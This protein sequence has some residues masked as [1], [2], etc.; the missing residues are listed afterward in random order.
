MAMYKRTLILFVVI[1]LTLSLGASGGVGAQTSNWT[2]DKSSETVTFGPGEDAITDTVT[3][4]NDDRNNS[5]SLSASIDG[6]HTVTGQPGT[7]GPGE[8]TDIQVELRSSGS[9]SATLTV[10]GGGKTERV[11]YT[12]ETP[13]YVEIS[14]IPDWLDDEGVLR[15]DSRTA[16]ITVEETGGHQGFNGIDI[17][18]DDDGIS[19]LENARVSAGGST[20]VTVTFTADN[21]ADQY[22]DIGG[23]LE[24]DPNELGTDYD[25]ESDV[26]LE[27][28]VAFPAQFGDV[29]LDLEEFE[30]DEPQS[31]GSITRQTT[32]EVENSGD[33]E[34]NF[35][36]V[37]IG[38]T[39]FSD[40]EVLSEPNSIGPGET[41]SVDL[42]IT[43][44]TSLDEGAYDFDATLYANNVD[45]S[46]LTDTVDIEH[47]VEMSVSTLE[48]RS[49]DVPIGNTDS[50]SITV[51]EELGY[52]DIENV[53][54]TLSEGP[55][56]WI[57]VTNDID[58]S[59]DTN[60]SSDV[61][62]EIQFGPNADIGSTYSWTFVISGDEVANREVTVSATP[63][64]L[65]LEPLKESLEEAPGESQ[66]LEQTSTETLE[67]VNQMDNQIRE[68]EIPREDVTT[69]LT[70]GDGVIRYLEAI[71]TVDNSVADGNH[72]AAQEELIRAAVA[73]D[74]MSVYGNA[75]QDDDLRS[76]ASS[77]RETAGTELSSRI[78]TQE[79]HYEEQLES[80]DTTPVEEA[81]IKTELARIASLQGDSERAESLEAEADSAFETYSTL[82]GEGETKRQEAIDDWEEMESDIF[83]TVVGQ[84]LILNPVH[85]DKFEDRSDTLLSAYDD[86][87][88]AF[89]EAGETTRAEAVTEERA[90]RANALT[91]ARWSLFVSMTIGAV[92]IISIITHT[93]RGMY[94]YIEDSKESISG[95][96]LM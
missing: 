86:A 14:G 75:I 95:D 2:L 31:V 12:V 87:E 39:P 30:F 7:L 59:I 19:G 68:G 37:A 10:N 90:Q 35:N 71:D 41:E 28:F 96:F 34:L 44:E 3:V 8:S 58:S 54:M 5:V 50:A 52:K 4:R 82:V 76:R 46:D 42:E 78:E 84:Q 93:A 11:D 65:N 63:I 91:I 45:S 22:D 17:Q 72:D 53:Q 9:E 57:K 61:E 20:T 81:R 24:L 55:Q 33:R 23:R 88:M 77:V 70:F 38:S 32:I 51:E 13:A 62:Y 83:V 60:G 80:G 15:G 85:Y 69:A 56:Q 40:V 26:T 1:S 73:F 21:S 92:I 89:T 64:P 27:T 47:G 16:Q 36:R 79:A 6:G 29:N 49:G 18:G 74:T 94:W 43:A 48:I 66:A 67:L 25:V